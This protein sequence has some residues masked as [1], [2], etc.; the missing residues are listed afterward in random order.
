MDPADLEAA[1][2]K[3]NAFDAELKI[4]QEAQEQVAS[5]VMERSGTPSINVVRNAQNNAQV[6]K[7]MQRVTLEGSAPSTSK[8]L[9]SRGLPRKVIGV[10]DGN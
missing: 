5:R 7:Q 2:K 9:I 6:R 3:R 10:G 1:R 4:K 8:S